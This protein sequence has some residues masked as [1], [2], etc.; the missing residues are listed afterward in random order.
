MLFRTDE[1]FDK[2][3]TPIFTSPDGG[4]HKVEILCRGQQIVVYGLHPDTHAPYTWRGGEPGPE[5]KRDA[6]PLLSAEKANEF[7]V[8]AARA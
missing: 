6:L 7:I 1:V 2:L 8:A 3:S 4:T 5:L